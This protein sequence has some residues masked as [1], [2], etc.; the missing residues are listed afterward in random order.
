MIKYLC[1]VENCGQEGNPPEGEKLT[2]QEIFYPKIKE[3]KYFWARIGFINITLCPE[4][5]KEAMKELVEL[6]KERYAFIT[7]SN[8]RDKKTGHKI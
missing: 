8:F 5:R 7:P 6:I 2:S 4:H 3:F 1:D